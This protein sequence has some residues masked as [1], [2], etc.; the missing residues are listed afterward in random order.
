MDKPLNFLDRLIAEAD[1]AL[2]T[3]A[4]A[5]TPTRPNPAG[6]AE[7]PPLTPDQARHVAGLMR[8]DHAGEI[9]AQALYQGQAL[10]ARN[11]QVRQMLRRAADEEGDHLA[12]CAERLKELGSRPSL[13]TPVW[14]M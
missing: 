3:M 8:I 2:R 6:D 4:N 10:T 5:I 12:W 9:C 7:H 14:Y 11:P 1:H 13:L